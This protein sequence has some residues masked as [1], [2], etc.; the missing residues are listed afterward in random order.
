MENRDDDRFFEGEEVSAIFYPDDTCV[1]VGQNLVEKI[2]V[3]MEYGQMAGVPWFAVWN[4]HKI[5][6]K[7][8]GAH[9]ACVSL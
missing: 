6:A 2:T 7:Y 8:N 1:K 3:V 9:I 5:I 4:D